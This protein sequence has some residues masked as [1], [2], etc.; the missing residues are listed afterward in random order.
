M[1]HLGL[2]VA[3]YEH[4]TAHVNRKAVKLAFF[5][6]ISHQHVVIVLLCNKIIVLRC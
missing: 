3:M 2:R 1:K 4:T 6:H 5:G